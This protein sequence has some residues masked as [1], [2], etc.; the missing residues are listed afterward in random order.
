MYL[1]GP[2]VP[3]FCNG[4]VANR[5]AEI[6]ESAAIEKWFY[7][8]TAKNPADV[9]TRGLAASALSE[10][11]WIKGPDFLKTL[12][13]PFKPAHESCKIPFVNNPNVVSLSSIT[14]PKIV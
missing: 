8:P 3:Q 14:T 1:C 4:F 2:I 10:S 11:G 12:D 7:V 5:V 13:W 9:G 6:R